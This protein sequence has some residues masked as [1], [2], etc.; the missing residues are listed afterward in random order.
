MYAVSNSRRGTAF[1]SRIV[2]DGLRMSGKTGTAQV[3]SNVV[4][5][6]S[7]P[8]EQRDHALFVNFAPHD[9]PRIA[10]SVVVE[11]GGGGSSAAAPIARDVTLQALYGEDPPLEAYPS[12]DRSRI[13]ALQDRLAR[14]RR[15]RD[16]EGQSRA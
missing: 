15:I 4:D 12:S 2:A 9:T 14:E 7:V 5:N 3:S 6:N 1:A 16:A 8:W 13:K 10:V 11:H